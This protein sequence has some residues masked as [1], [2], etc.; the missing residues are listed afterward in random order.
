MVQPQASMFWQSAVKSGLLDATKLE[1]CWEAIPL[2][3]R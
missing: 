2:E 1:K 3:K